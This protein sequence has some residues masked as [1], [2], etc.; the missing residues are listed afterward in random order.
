MSIIVQ[1]LGTPGR[2]NAVAVSVNGGQ[3]VARL[4]FDCGAACLTELSVAEILATEHLFFS[5]LHMDHVGGFDDFF[6]LTFARSS[7]A[8][9]IWGPPGTGR[10]L[11]HRFQGFLW[12]LHDRL[13]GSWY[14]HDIYPASIE[15]SRYE[16]AE[17]FAA[18]HAEGSRPYEQLIW[19]CAE[20]SVQALAMAH[21]TPSLAYIIREQA[22]VNV[23]PAR[24]AAL[25]LAPGPWLGHVKYPAPEVQTVLIHGHSYDL[26][27]LRQD[28]IVETPGAAVAYLTDFLLDDPAMAALVPALQGCDTIVCESQYRHADIALARQNYHMTSVLAASLA[29]Q[30]A[31]RQLVLFHVSDRYTRAEWQQ[32]LREARA[33]FPQ[34][35]YPQHWQLEG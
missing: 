17:A 10:I 26:D 21:R 22:R 14:V 5:H 11:Q 3:R 18:A 1:A 8:N 12:N 4:L 32:M 25:G 27:R 23:D 33:I 30:A 28:L 19:R 13:A 6:R 31:A 20:Y 29:K 34:T 9:H 16:L 35:S 7:P 15:T 24:L 2:D